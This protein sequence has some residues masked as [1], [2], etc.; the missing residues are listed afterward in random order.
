M[1]HTDQGSYID[2]LMHLFFSLGLCGLLFPSKRESAFASLRMYESIGFTVSAAYA[3]FLCM[4]IKMYITGAVLFVSVLC[5]FVM[6][7]VRAQEKNPKKKPVTL[8]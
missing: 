1:G 3:Q 5:Y 2:S 4:D 6:E 7:S 8:V